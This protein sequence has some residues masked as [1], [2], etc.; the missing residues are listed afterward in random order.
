MGTAAGKYYFTADVHLGSKDDTDGR[1]ERE[2]LAF[3]QSIP[4]DAR[5]LYLLG[6]IFDFWVDWRDVVPRGYVRILTALAELAA[7]GVDVR[8]LPGNHDWWVT[9]YFEEELGVKIIHENW[10]LMEIEGKRICAGHGDMPGAADFKSRLIFHLFRSRFWIGVLKTLH[11]RL[12]FGLA[13]KW[14][15]HSRKGHPEDLEVTSTG[16]YRFVDEFGRMR[17]EAGEA[18]IDLYIFGHIHTPARI[19]V[20]S[21]GELIVLGDWSQGAKYFCL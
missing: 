13:R 1:L 18:P 5:G 7:R 16:L 21:G 3:L 10:T 9:D 14:S 15:A 4:A 11:P 20:P 8:F 19:P 6:D 12:A 2:F 17:A